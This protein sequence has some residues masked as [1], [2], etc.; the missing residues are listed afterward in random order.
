MANQCSHARQ[1]ERASTNLGPG[2][3]FGRRWALAARQRMHTWRERWV[4]AQ[5]LE[6]LDDLVFAEL[7]LT[8]WQARQLVKAHPRATEQLGKMLRHLDLDSDASVDESLLHNDLYRNCALCMHHRACRR[9][10]DLAKKGDPYPTF[11]PNG[12]YF[13]RLLR[14]R[15]LASK[16]HDEPRA[17]S[18]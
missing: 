13:G 12:W 4:E 10:F 2:G 17:P 9:W 18:A 6:T 15:R 16:S 3:W 14:R 11:C 1:A 7:G 5:E 8:R